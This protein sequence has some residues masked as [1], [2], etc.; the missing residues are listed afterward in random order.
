MAIFD[1]CCGRGFD[2]A[3]M[4]RSRGWRYVTND[5]DPDVDCDTHRD[6]RDWETLTA[7][8]GDGWTVVSNPP[9]T[10]AS[11]L[12]EN[13]LRSDRIDA[14]AL[15]LRLTFL[16]PSKNRRW[17]AEFADCM[18]AVAPLNPRPRFRGDGRGTDSATVAWFAW[19]KHFSW[20]ESG[21]EAPFRFLVDWR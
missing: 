2:H 14:V 8:M 4:V 7:D 5:I 20:R 9:Y 19:D 10:L 16:E 12:A 15:L 13:A 11:E 3:E 6:I 21:V 17:L 18:T 1:P